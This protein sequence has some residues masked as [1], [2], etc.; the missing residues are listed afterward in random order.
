MHPIYGQMYHSVHVAMQV[1]H[2]S[3]YSIGYSVQPSQECMQYYAERKIMVTC[4]KSFSNQFQYTTEQ[5]Q[6]DRINLL[7]M[8]ESLTVFNKQLI[9]FK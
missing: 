9:N 8:E 2:V 4:H 1:Y 5:S 3:P 7:Y 6:F